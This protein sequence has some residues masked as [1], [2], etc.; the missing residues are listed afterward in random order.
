MPRASATREND[1]GKQ[2]HNQLQYFV[3]H[4]NQQQFYFNL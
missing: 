4:M 3:S 1:R 2:H